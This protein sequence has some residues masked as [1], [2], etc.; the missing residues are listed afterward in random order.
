MTIQLR[1]GRDGPASLT[2]VRSD[3]SR[4]WSRVHPFFPVHDLTHYAIESVLGF[5]EAFFG[6]VASGWSL[7]DFAPRVA[8][9]SEARV[10]ESIV[11]VFDLERA[12]PRPFTAAE[13]NELLHPSLAGQ[14]LERFR[15]IRDVEVQQVRDLQTRLADAW[16]ALDLGG[17]LD[18]PFPAP[19]D[20][21]S[22]APRP[23]A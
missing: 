23:S 19:R 22:G 1:K 18:I 12:Q 5:T 9:P 14:R 6:L 2:C 7:D 8:L 13:F 16:G 3:G 20:G 17:T 10:A 21:G 15:P 11:G 4:T